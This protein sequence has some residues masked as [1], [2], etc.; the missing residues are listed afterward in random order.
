MPLRL[1]TISLTVSVG[2]TESVTFFLPFAAAADAA[3]SVNASRCSSHSAV[4][5]A[6]ADRGRYRRTEVSPLSS[7]L[8]DSLP[9]PR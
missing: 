8:R 5:R 3:A 2:R 7:S 6:I 1:V 9:S 4:S